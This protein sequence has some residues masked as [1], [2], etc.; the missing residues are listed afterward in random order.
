MLQNETKIFR[1]I[2]FFSAC[3]GL[4]QNNLCEFVQWH[5]CFLINIAFTV[6]LEPE[7]SLSFDK[8]I[9]CIQD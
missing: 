5:R 1:E 7:K 8:L 2:S 3:I 6:I 4:W 9:Q